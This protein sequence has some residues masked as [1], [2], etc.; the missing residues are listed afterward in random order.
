[1]DRLVGA[2]LK[3][4]PAELRELLTASGLDLDTMLRLQPLAELFVLAREA[5]GWNLRQAAKLAAVKPK[6]LR[7]LED[8]D[9][10]AVGPWVVPYAV[11]VGLSALVGEWIT[12]NPAAAARFGWPAPNQLAQIFGALMHATANSAPPA[13]P[14]AT[15]G[16]RDMFVAPPDF[17]DRFSPGRLNVAVEA[18]TTTAPPVALAALLEE[19]LADEALPPVATV[20]LP[21]ASVATATY[22][23]KVSLGAVRPQI[24]RRFTVP[25]TLTFAQFHEVLQAVMGWTNAHLHDFAFRGQTI[26]QPDPEWPRPTLREDRTRLGEIGLKPRSKLVY[27]YD[28]GDGWEHA[29]VLEK[30]L[31]PDGEDALACLDGQRACPP[32]DCGGVPGYQ[33]LCALLAKPE[34]QDPDGVREWA[35]NFD[36][37][38]FDLERVNAT[39]QRL[40]KRWRPATPRSRPKK[41]PPR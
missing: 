22:Q 31:P 38:A 23:F 16:P 33:N 34:R 30:V 9:P 37:D 15:Q 29:V 5:R 11:R 6:A 36:P 17:A 40:A 24:W 14:G 10:A 19:F 3:S 20:T 13:G 8:C 1:M 21:G 2:L 39:L 25:S 26:G 7:T 28:F 18:V 4:V 35:G 41:R 12:A 32:E 27:R